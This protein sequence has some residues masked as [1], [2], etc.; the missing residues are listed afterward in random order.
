MRPM[1][2]Q[3]G[4]RRLR[5]R[6][7]NLRCQ[8]V[9]RIDADLFWILKRTCVNT[10]ERNVRRQK[11]ADVSLPG[12]LA[13]QENEMRPVNKKTSHTFEK[14]ITLAEGNEGYIKL[15][16][17]PGVFMPLSVEKIAPNTYAFAHYY[18]QNSDMMRYPEILLWRS[19]LNQRL[20]P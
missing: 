13:T 19:S 17:A 20:Y 9:G 15:D 14:L 18:E 3:L 11:A 12:I 1:G 16:N 10:P 6:L 5:H 8:E 2:R 4:V 7:R